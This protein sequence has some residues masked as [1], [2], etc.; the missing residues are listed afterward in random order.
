MSCVTS[1]SRMTYAFSR[2]RAVPGW[3][4]WSKVDRNGTPVN[5]IIGATIAGLVLT[6]PAL[7]KSPSGAPTAFYAVVSVAV[8]GL[9]LAFLI[10]IALRLRMGDR[11]VPGPWTLGRKYKVLGWIAVI[12]IAVICVYFILPIAPAGI[13]G[14]EEFTWTAV[15]YAPIAVGGLLLIGVAL[16]AALGEELVH[17]SAAYGRRTGAGG[18]R[19]RPALGDEGPMPNER[20][21]ATPMAGMPVWRPVRGG[22]AF[23]ITVSRLAQAIRLGL[24]SEGERLPAERELAERLQVSRVTLREAIRALREAGFLES[25]RGRSGGT[26][27]VSPTGLGGAGAIGK[28]E[29]GGDAG[30]GG[31]PRRRRRAAA[32][33]VAAPPAPGVVATVRAAGPSGAAATGGTGRSARGSARSA[34]GGAASA[35]GSVALGAGGAAELARQMGDSL[36]DAL[37]FRRVLEPGAAGLAASRTLAGRRP[38]A[39]RRLPGRLARP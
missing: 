24:V 8:I 35:G 27:V 1:M 16:V 34:R 3:R 14:N 38:A 17:R 5:A 12:E 21:A 6:L 37:D 9:Y 39:A 19:S 26:F 20:V 13:P 18:R 28:G 2:D 11:F 7:Y 15:N 22:N 29:D 4:M 36:P 32:A 30:A 10:P 25:R 33:A 31:A 23:E